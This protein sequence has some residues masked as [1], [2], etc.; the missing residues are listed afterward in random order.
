MFGWFK[1]K[2]SPKEFETRVNANGLDL[3]AC[4]YILADNGKDTVVNRHL[5]RR[6]DHLEQHA[7]KMRERATTACTRLWGTVAKNSNGEQPPSG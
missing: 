7:S 4:F 2:M 5:Q 6:A 1:N 3:D